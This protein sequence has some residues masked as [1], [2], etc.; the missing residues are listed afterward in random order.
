MLVMKQA[1]I[2]CALEMMASEHLE[3][4][5]LAESKWKENTQEDNRETRFPS[6]MQDLPLRQQRHQ[7]KMTEQPSL[8]EKTV[9]ATHQFIGV[10][11]SKA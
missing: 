7:P 6:T 4:N 5:E 11:T 3:N 2:K 9:L 1:E 10:C 8:C